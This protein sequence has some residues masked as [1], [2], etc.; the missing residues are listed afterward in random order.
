VLSLIDILFPT[1]P[2]FPNTHAARYEDIPAAAWRLGQFWGGAPG[3][4]KT[5]AL[6]RATVDHLIEHP[7]EPMISFD[8][9]QNF[10]DAFLTIVLSQPKNIRDSLIKRIIYDEIGHPTYTITLP[11]FHESYEVPMEKQIQRAI[12]NFE[13][14]NPELMTQTPVVGGVSISQYGRELCRLLTAIK[15]G[16]GST[17]QLTEGKYLLTDEPLLRRMLAK[18]GGNAGNAKWFFEHQFQE[19]SDNEKYKRTLGLISVLEDIESS[20]IRPR[21]GYHR[22]S[23]TMAQLVREAKIYLLNA[24]RINDEERPMAYEFVRVK[25]MFMN[26]IAKRMPNNPDDPPVTILFDEVPK[27]LNFMSRDITSF[28]TYFRAKKLQPIIVAQELSQFTEDIRPH[29]W[30]YANIVLF[31]MYNFNDRFEAAQQLF[32]YQSDTVKAQAKTLTQQNI[33]EPDRGQYLQ[34]ANELYNMGH[35]ECIVRR[36]KSETDTNNELVWVKKTKEAPLTATPAELQE[37]KEMKMQAYGTRVN[38]VNT[39]IHRRIKEGRRH[40]NTSTEAPTID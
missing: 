22:P 32:P 16:Y 11:E 1:L 21:I 13:A 18:W 26:E 36:Q 24:V 14:L 25:S 37:L 34:I 29:L 5:M 3:R 35:R 27:V 40:N 33:Y 17:W 10:T 30:G 2:K 6:A 4:G 9:N 8:A 28:S 19:L 7:D 15:N 12:Q 20:A 23:F 31:S 39:S 38:D